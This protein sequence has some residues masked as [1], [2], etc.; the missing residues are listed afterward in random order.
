MAK[1]EY[2]KLLEEYK[3]KLAQKEKENQ[4]LKNIIEDLRHDKVTG[5]STRADGERLLAQHFRNTVFDDYKHTDGIAILSIDIDHFK[6]VNDTNGHPFGDKVLEIFARKLSENTNPEKT[7]IVC[8]WGGD[9]FLIMLDDVDHDR[10]LEIADKVRHD[11]DNQE[12]VDY[13]VTPSIGVLHIGPELLIKEHANYLKDP[14]MALGNTINY[15]V[16][17][18]DHALYKAKQNG[19][20]QVCDYSDGIIERQL[21]EGKS[22]K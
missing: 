8:R 3:A 9:E 7:D 18:V 20:D 19:R 17:E 22:I 2:E 13:H 15:Y 4:K 16:S 11:I 14:E 12:D 1:E 10:A 5:L 21:N 6:E